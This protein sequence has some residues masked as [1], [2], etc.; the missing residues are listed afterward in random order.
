MRILVIDDELAVGATISMALRSKGFEAVAVEGLADGLRELNNSQ[1]DLAIVDIFLQGAVTGVTAIRALRERTPGMSIIATS[2]ITP[3]ELDPLYPDMD[4]V[5][6]LSKPFRPNDLMHAIDEAVRARPGAA[7]EGHPSDESREQLFVAAVESSDDA[8]ITKS[9]D[10]IITGWNHAAQLL[11]GFAPSEAIGQSIDIIVPEE[12]RPE[13]RAILASIRSGEK[14]S[15]HDTVRLTKDGRRIGISLSVSPVKS[16][17]GAIIGAAKVARDNAARLRE[18]RAL[19]ESEQLAQAIIESSLDAFVQLDQGGTI[20]RWSPNAEAML[21]WSPSEAV[22]RNL[23]ELIIPERRRAA[24]LRRLQ[25]FIHDFENGMPGWRYESPSLRRDGSEILTEVSLTAIRRDDGY[26]INGFL[27]DITERR[28]AE[29]Q[30]TQAQKMESVGQLTGGIAHDFNNMLAIITGT[31]D[32]LA[33]AV[34]DRPDLAQIAKLISDAADRGAELTSRLLAFARQQPLQPRAVDV[35]ELVA[36]VARLLHP[37]LGEQIEISICPTDEACAALVDPNQLSAAIVN[38]AINAR[39]AM[40]DGGK[41]EIQSS[42]IVF[43]Q[44]EIRSDDDVPPGCYVLISVSDTGVGIPAALLTKVFEPFFTTKEAG[45]GT[46]LGLSMVYGFVKQ[47]GGQIRIYSEEGCGTTFKMFLPKADRA[48]D[49]TSERSHETFEGG[50]ETILV[51]EDN[52]AVRTSVISQLHLLGYNTLVAANASEARAIV[53]A[54]AAF[55]LLFT[56]VIMPGPMNGTQLALEVARR[57]PLVKVLFTSGYPQNAL[58]HQG[59]IDPG[60]CCSPSPIGERTLLECFVWRWIKKPDWAQSDEL[61][62][63]A[64]TPLFAT[65][66]YGH[67]CCLESQ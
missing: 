45:A 43:D 28:A 22:G 47:S 37:T 38:L 15:H 30:L 51:V 54:G 26:I 66:S 41:L 10:G 13:V 63:R 42:S 64:Y 4:D 32:I 62:A 50:T 55:D 19:R 48:A 24:D 18:H 16:R 12:L 49:R 3:L 27:R 58:S 9:L 44:D 46:G 29:E 60:C 52:V 23:R 5:K 1:F 40:P 61:C 17:S 7:A 2:G 14:V 11:F 35:N 20:L 36:E 56:D 31:I 34:A 59:R 21:G 65:R 39:D 8:I 33:T 57:R 53:E 25:K 6:Y 67:P